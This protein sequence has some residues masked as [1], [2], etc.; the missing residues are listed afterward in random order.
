MLTNAPSSEQEHKK[1]TVYRM[2]VQYRLYMV[3]GEFVLSHPHMQGEGIAQQ[4]SN[5]VA[6][7]LMSYKK[8]NSN[9]TRL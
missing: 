3:A 1:S 8:D 6:V 5:W 7:G 4:F 2:N 9:C